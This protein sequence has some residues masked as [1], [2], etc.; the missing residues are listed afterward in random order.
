MLLGPAS[1]ICVHRFSNS[2]TLKKSSI[3]Y[4]HPLKHSEYFFLAQVAVYTIPTLHG[5][6]NKTNQY[7][8]PTYLNQEERRPTVSVSMAE[9]LK[10]NKI[11]IM[12]QNRDFK[13][14]G[15]LYTSIKSLCNINMGVFLLS[16]NTMCCIQLLI[17]TNG[18]T[19]YLG[20]SWD[21]HKHTYSVWPYSK[22]RKKTVNY[23][24][25][26]VTKSDILL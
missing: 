13:E 23:N 8:N 9:S 15:L 16:E 5:K 26:K 6:I 17:G 21:S 4:R 10:Q 3:L 19:L 1:D 24:N 18:C 2:S 25:R 11:K 14:L 7:Q 12:C 20:V 22:N